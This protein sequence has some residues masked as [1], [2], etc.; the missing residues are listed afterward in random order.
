MDAV[1]GEEEYE[2]RMDNE[3]DDSEEDERTALLAGDTPSYNGSGNDGTVR[4]RKK[5]WLGLFKSRDEASGST[6]A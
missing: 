2:E 4:K 5:G 6:N 3:D 1:F